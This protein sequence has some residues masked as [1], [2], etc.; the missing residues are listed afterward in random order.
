MNPDLQVWSSKDFKL[1]RTLA[2]HEGKVRAALH[3][4]M[5]ALV[6]SPKRVMVK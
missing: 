6:Q 4:V 2:G 1:L 3:G 5:T